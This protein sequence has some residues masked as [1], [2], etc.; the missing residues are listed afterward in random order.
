MEIANTVALGGLIS[1]TILIMAGLLAIFSVR[2]MFSR[3]RHSANSVTSDNS[4][5]FHAESNSRESSRSRSGSINSFS[6][7][8]SATSFHTNKSMGS[9][10]SVM[11]RGTM[12]TTSESKGILSEDILITEN[13]TNRKLPSS[14]ENT[15]CELGM[16]NVTSAKGVLKFVTPQKS[17]QN[18]QNANK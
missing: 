12:T 6:R 3:N 2:A 7:V 18:D 5:S 16:N 10:V 15:T 1:C 4:N 17:D 14:N 8:S 9:I 11:S 13:G